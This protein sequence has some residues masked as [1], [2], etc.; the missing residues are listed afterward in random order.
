LI[1]KEQKLRARR[2]GITREINEKKKK[3]ENIKDLLK[4]GKELPEKIK[5]LTENINEK[6]EEVN[7][8]LYQIPNII[9]KDVPLGKDH[10][11]N[12]E[13]AKYGIPT[14]FDFKPKNHVDLAEALKIV[15]FDGSARVAGKGFFYLLG[16]LVK[17]NQAIIHFALDFMDK[18]GYTLVEP[19]LMLNRDHITTVMPSADF[20]EHAYKIEDRNQILI[21]TSEHPLV[22][23]FKDQ[24][25]EKKK[26]PIKLCGFSQC[27]R[28]E[29][30]SHGIEEKGLFR[31]HQFNKIEQ[32]VICEPGDS[33][34][35]YKEILANSIELFQKLGIPIRIYESC[36]GDLGDLKYKGEDVEAWSPIKKEYYEIGSCSNLTDAQARRANSSP[37]P[38]QYC[39]RNLKMPG[40]YLRELPK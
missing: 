5:E 29:I 37:F 11:E 24:V 21:A 10:T 7:E 17:L 13:T 12:K 14:T 35:F 31:T 27:F 20:E 38:K 25:I 2:N 28:Q 16:D 32:V 3:K 1:Q 33:E 4:E 19:P 8:L 23:W 36:S 15:D 6:K 26:L 18:K 22:V 34:K 30:G 9:A 40:C 39:N